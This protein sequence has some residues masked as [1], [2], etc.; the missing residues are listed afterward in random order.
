[1]PALAGS[2]VSE[3]ETAVGPDTTRLGG[4]GIIPSMVAQ[5]AAT[6][7]SA[8][9][10]AFRFSSAA[11]GAVERCWRRADPPVE[12]GLTRET[13]VAAVAR[14]AAQRFSG[15]SPDDKQVEG[16]L[17]S[18]H[19]RDLALAR[20]A[21]AGNE[22]AWDFFMAEY[23]Q[24]MY[25]AARAISG[26]PDS[27]DAGARELAD[28]LYADLYGLRESAGGSRKSLFDYF[29]GR[30]KLSTWLRAILAQ[31][32]VDEIRRAQKTQPIEDQDGGEK[33][34][35]AWKDQT[36][37]G[38]RAGDPERARQMAM[39]QGALVMA[40]DALGARD[41][42]RLAYYYADE[43]TLAE[44]GRMLREHEA[45]VSRKLD[46]TRRELRRSVEAALREG[47]NLSSEQIEACFEHAREQWPFDLVGRLRSG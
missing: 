4:S 40:L 24:E 10:T 15:D 32:Y 1:V 37:D 39:L 19:A 7:S 3:A 35:I 8:A 42:L 27:Q 9:A 6:D 18:L 20:A 16:Y 29:H 21:S 22:A 45:T 11:A 12:W 41:R 13:F 23:R 2:P 30:S 26:R 47:K 46:R 14:S 31:R 36:S 5:Q 17:D 25:R 44:I 38:D 43:L 34:G 33:Q 28:S